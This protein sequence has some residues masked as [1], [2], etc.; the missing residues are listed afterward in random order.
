MSLTS[1]MTAMARKR[2]KPDRFLH[3]FHA[4]DAVESLFDVN[5][6]LSRNPD[7]AATNLNPFEH[8]LK[9]GATE[10]RDP[11][12]FFDSDWYLAQNPDVAATNLNPLIHYA[13][14]AQLSANEWRDPHP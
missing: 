2:Y 12:P 13:Q 11:N 10:G 8:Y 3:G 6:Y 9:I 1:R 5:W 7:V 4:S 14:H